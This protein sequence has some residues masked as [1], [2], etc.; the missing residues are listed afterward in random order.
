MEKP[1]LEVFFSC[2]CYPRGRRPHCEKG[3]QVGEFW[4][5]NGN[6]VGKGNPGEE[7]F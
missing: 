1:R 3:C 7:A 6:K 4:R 5:D 2:L